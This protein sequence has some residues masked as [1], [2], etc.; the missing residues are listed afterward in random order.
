MT[1]ASASHNAR[2]VAIAQV[3]KIGTQLIGLFVFSRLLGASEYGLMALA[4]TV[5]NFSSVLLDLG[6]ASAIIQ[7]DEVKPALLDSI[8]Y[9][10]LAIA[11][12]MFM[13]VLISSHWVV[14][15]YQQPKLGTLLPFVSVVFLV[16]SLF[17]AQRALLE[18][19]SRFTTIAFIEVSG[20]WV[21]LG[22]GVLMAF[23]THSAYAI[24][25]QMVVAALVTCVLYWRKSSWRPS[26]KIQFVELRDIL[27]FSA[28][29]SAF[30]LVNY[31]SRNSD[32][33]IIGRYLGM[34]AT[35][36]YSL[37]YNIM[38]FPVQS[39][40]FVATR[41]MYPVL[42][43]RKGDAPAVANLYLRCVRSISFFSAPAMIGIWSVRN[44]LI[45][46][47]F[48]VA[49]APAIPLL[50]WMALTGYV[51]SLLSSTGTVFMATGRT[52][53]MLRV[54]TLGTVLAVAAFLAG[55]SG[56][57]ER[58]VLY[59]FIAN[60]INFVVTF[61]CVAW[62]LKIS[63][64]RIVGATLPSLGS[65]IV[66]ALVIVAVDH[67][68]GIESNVLRLALLVLCGA[69]GYALTIVL[70]SRGSLQDVK[71]IIGVKR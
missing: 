44:P 69:L 57:L 56:G 27:G 42:S 48:G 61:A 36:V 5:I 31:F 28:N 49:W 18:K 50:A 33:F 53:L 9:L 64:L 35:G 26:A 4:M 22:V 34:A 3:S 1:I 41:A 40:T 45:H 39:M 16:N 2:W 25:L 68:S 54:G 58:L 70:V 66:M 59:Y 15:Y 24:A 52:D 10:N 19:E 51:Q 21:G 8:F 23:M 32:R 46:T 62:L 6:T 71:A 12:V 38:L 37:A 20:S 17:I 43:A 55:I 63:L 30:N 67:F 47:F 65:A 14:G 29:L 13:I 7:K 60:L 11:I